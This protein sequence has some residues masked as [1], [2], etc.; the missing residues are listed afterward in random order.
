MRKI[1]IATALCLAA[2]QAG[3]APQFL[4]GSD[5]ALDSGIMPKINMAL[6]KEGVRDPLSAQYHSLAP[7]TVGDYICGYINLKNGYGAYNGFKAFQYN[8]KKDSINLLTAKP[9]EITWNLSRLVFS[10][11]GCTEVLDLPGET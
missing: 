1:L 3:A 9:G 8:L 4:D 7:G 2:L 6:S 10:F 11:S 5:S